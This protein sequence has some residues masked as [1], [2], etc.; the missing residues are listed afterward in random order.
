[1]PDRTATL[2]AA[3]GFVLPGLD[4]IV[5]GTS[6]SASEERQPFDTYFDTADLRL[7]RWGCALRHRE[8]EG[9]T[10]VIPVASSGRAQGREEVPVR[11]GLTEP[12]AEALAVVSALIRDASVMPVAWCRAREVAYQWRAPGPPRYCI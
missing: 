4:S 2:V 6:R 11:S 1:V 12:P 7:T 3:E 9:W 10:V 5:P 8:G